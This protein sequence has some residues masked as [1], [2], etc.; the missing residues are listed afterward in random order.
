VPVTFSVRNPAGKNSTY[1]GLTNGSGVAKV[2]VRLKGK[3]PK[4]TYTVTATASSGGMTG[5]ASGTFSY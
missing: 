1:S 5:S 3:D 4:G 2:T